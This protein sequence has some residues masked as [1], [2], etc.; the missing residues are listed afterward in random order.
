MRAC[1]VALN[2]ARMVVGSHRSSGLCSV[3]AGAAVPAH[4]HAQFRAGPRGAGV[5]GLF[6]SSFI[7]DG[8]DQLGGKSCRKSASAEAQAVTDHWLR[9]V[10]APSARAPLHSIARLRMIPPVLEALPPRSKLQPSRANCQEPAAIPARHSSLQLHCTGWA[11]PRFS[12]PVS[13]AKKSKKSKTRTDT[14]WAC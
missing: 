11:D 14:C 8:T 4:R 12:S 10:A 3:W 7:I 9:C 13:S 5:W 6:V 2:P 1:H